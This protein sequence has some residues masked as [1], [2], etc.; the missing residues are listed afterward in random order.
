MKRPEHPQVWLGWLT[1]GMAHLIFGVPEA[2]IRW[3]VS[4]GRVERSIHDGFMYLNAEHL[5]H[6]TEKWL[7][8]GANRHK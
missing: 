6:E 1:P 7:G 4:L 2:T 8:R 5:R 3:W